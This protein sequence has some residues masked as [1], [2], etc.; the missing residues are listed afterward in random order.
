MPGLVEAHIGRAA[1]YAETGR[2]EAAI[3]QLEIAT[4]LQPDSPAIRD[5]LEKLRTSRKQ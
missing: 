1:G 3:D 2:L 5:N 4:R